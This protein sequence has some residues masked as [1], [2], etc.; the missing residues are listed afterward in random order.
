[1]PEN[2]RSSP[3]DYIYRKTL[4][5]GRE[6][7]RGVPEQSGNG[8]SAP[9]P[10]GLTVLKETVARKAYEQA[11]KDVSG[12]DKQP[13][14]EDNGNVPVQIEHADDYGINN[15]NARNDDMVTYRRVQGGR[16]IYD[17]ATEIF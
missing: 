10:D 12:L 14:M 5:Q 13:E 8:N 15:Q 6:A 17:I 11:Q 4:E 3:E 16:S 2:R 1:M 9:A 7:L